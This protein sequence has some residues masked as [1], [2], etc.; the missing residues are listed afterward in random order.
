MNHC[1]I[2]AYIYTSVSRY[3]AES[4]LRNSWSQVVIR[5]HNSVKH[6]YIC[7]NGENLWK[8]L[9]DT[10]ELKKVT[11]QSDLMAIKRSN[12]ACVYM[13]N[14]IQY[15]WCEQCGPWASYW[16][17]VLHTC[18]IFIWNCK[19]YIFWFI[20]NVYVSRPKKKKKKK[21]KKKSGIT[22]SNGGFSNEVCSDCHRLKLITLLRN[23]NLAVLTV[24][25]VVSLGRPVHCL[26]LV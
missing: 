10:T 4:I 22:S 5:D 20:S 15:D 19:I 18:M 7:F 21:K 17:D 6:I 8:S 9:Q 12:F 3:C 24:P 25:T 26:S 2:K 13:R 11:L 23:S 14:L 16:N 1:T